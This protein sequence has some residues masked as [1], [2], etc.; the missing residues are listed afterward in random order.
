MLHTNM[1]FKGTVLVAALA[2]VA[3][4]QLD[5]IVF[6]V[7]FLM[8][9]HGGWLYTDS[10]A[11]MNWLSKKVHAMPVVDPKPIPELN[12][13]NFSREAM[14]RL[15]NNLADPIVIRGA[16]K[17]TEAI[18]QWSLEF[19]E[20]FYPKDVF[21]VREM[22][23]DVVRMQQRPFEDFILMKNKGRNVS[24]VASS[25]VFHDN[26]KLRKQLESPIEEH[27]VGP[28]GEPI[29][30]NQF[31]MTPGGR[32]WFHCAIGNNV[33]RQ[34]VG[35]KR[36]T[37]IDPKKYSL[38]LCP[39]PV[40]TGTSVTSCL[41]NGP[42]TDEREEWITHIPR[43]S[44]LLNPGDILVNS[45]WWWHDVQSIGDSNYPIVSVAGRIKN[46]KKTFANSPVMTTNAIATKLL[47]KSA[48]DAVDFEL[49]LQ[50]EIVASW[51]RNCISRGRTDCVTPP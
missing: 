15:S 29:I 36:W 30:A 26:P 1:G 4:M 20:E 45:G 21:V 40:I 46:I 12:M 17:E 3:Y 25:K 42:S 19:F 43:F 5:N 41:E 16:I 27:L 51:T 28:N 39:V 23:D 22:I 10:P 6:T 47:S 44:A 33:F 8:A 38:H 32:T 9:A 18:S 2:A 48:N 34:V 50:E 35:Q 31:F 14:L 49:S 11:Y 37:V 13:E 7:A 24:I